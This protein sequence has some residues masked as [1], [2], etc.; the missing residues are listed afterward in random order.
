MEINLRHRKIC[1]TAIELTII[2]GAARMIREQIPNKI[3]EWCRET[4]PPLS[5]N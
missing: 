1:K 3:I 4:R 5:E 2:D